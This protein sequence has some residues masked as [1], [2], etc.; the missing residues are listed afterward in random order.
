MMPHGRPPLKKCQKRMMI[1]VRSFFFFALCDGRT[2]LLFSWSSPSLMLVAARV[3]V[4]RR[5]LA[6]TAT[7]ISVGS[8]VK[9]TC[10]CPSRGRQEDDGPRDLFCVGGTAWAVRRRCVAVRLRQAWR[11]RCPHAGA[12]EG[13]ASRA[14][15]VVTRGS[16]SRKAASM[17]FVGL[18]MGKKCR[19]A[20]CSLSGA[21]GALTEL[22]RQKGTTLWP[23]HS[24]TEE[25]RH[26]KNTKVAFTGTV[27]M[28]LLRWHLHCGSSLA[29]GVATAS[30]RVSPSTQSLSEEVI[31]R[32]G[33]RRGRPML[34]V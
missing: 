22:Q 25:T 15:I 14:C 3:R 17:W 29:G 7:A 26:A 27:R 33:G 10:S 1:G 24:S 5:W 28:P 6:A 8:L 21:G 11:S 31:V 18:R 16:V 30:R 4:S 13:R 23:L 19:P 34:Q 9:R 32:E 12:R 20:E 2:S